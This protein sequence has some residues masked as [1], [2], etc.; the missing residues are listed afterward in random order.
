M[1]EDAGIEWIDT[2][3]SRFV[4]GRR[5]EDTQGRQSEGE[6][7]VDGKPALVYSYKNVTPVGNYPFTSK[8]WVGQDTG[9]PM[10]IYVEYTNGTLKNMTVNYDTETKV[11]IEP[12]VG[13]EVDRVAIDEF[14]LFRPRNRNGIV[15]LNL[16]VAIRRV[17][18]RSLNRLNSSTLTWPDHLPR[19]ERR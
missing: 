6:D 8:I 16:T 3:S 15:R 2:E 13:S 1:D 7:S 9:V 14:S 12:P 18:S 4:Y 19:G 5:F 10:K 11:T 17:F